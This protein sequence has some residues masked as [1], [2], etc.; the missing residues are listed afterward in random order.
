MRLESHANSANIPAMYIAIAA[1]LTSLSCPEN[2]PRMA[3]TINPIAAD[4]TNAPPNHQFQHTPDFTSS[5]L[6]TAILRTKG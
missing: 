6:N 3:A 5:G 2:R 4:R 1:S